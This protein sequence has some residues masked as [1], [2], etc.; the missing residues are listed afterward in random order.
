MDR[1]ILEALVAARERLELLDPYDWGAMETW[2][3]SMRPILVASLPLQVDGF[4][5]VTTTPRWVASPRFSSTD[6]YGRQ[7][8]NFAEAARADEAAN[9]KIASDAKQKILG[10][11]AGVL[12]IPVGFTRTASMA[13]QPPSADA[14]KRI[15]IHNYGEAHMGDKYTSNVTGSTVGAVAVGDHAVSTGHVTIGTPGPVTQEQ[16]KAAISQ[17]QSALVQD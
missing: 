17:A 9:R 3:A 10:Y 1:A 16:H 6:R 13:N 12:A 5:H 7:R 2:V 14:A 4:D 15:V 8:D 11:L